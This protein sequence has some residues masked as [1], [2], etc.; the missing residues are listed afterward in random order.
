M[1][2]EPLEYALLPVLQMEDGQRVQH[3][4]TIAL[5]KS[6]PA[7]A[8][9]AR[10]CPGCALYTSSTPVSTSSLVVAL[11]VGHSLL[12]LQRKA[13]LSQVMPWH[14]GGDA[15]AISRHLLLFGK[16]ELRRYLLLS[17]DHR[18]A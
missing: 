3:S 14:L 1:S 16:G 10:R 2:S 13:Q 12:A 15:T 4:E 7:T 6:G 17:T 18:S 5:P 8:E 11:L 9:R